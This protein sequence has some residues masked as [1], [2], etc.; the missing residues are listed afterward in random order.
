MLVLK[1]SDQ[2]GTIG[3]GD[4]RSAFLLSWSEH[5]LNKIIP[6]SD[7]GEPSPSWIFFFF[8]TQVFFLITRFSSNSMNLEISSSSVCFI[9]WQTCW[10]WSLLNFWDPYCAIISFLTV[11]SFPHCKTR[12]GF[13]RVHLPIVYLRYTLHVF[14]YMVND[15]LALT[16]FLILF[17]F[18][19][20]LFCLALC[21][22]LKGISVPKGKS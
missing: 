12:L 7:Q 21:T 8:S 6:N 13:P 5:V 20:N 4:Q 10:W 2:C 9:I 19:L 3:K 14:S 15:M 18:C 1:Q 22:W 16:I 17:S 11:F